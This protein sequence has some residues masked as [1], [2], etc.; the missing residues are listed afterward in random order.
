M[1]GIAWA[2]IGLSGMAELMSE[3]LGTNGEYCGELGTG[4]WELKEWRKKLEFCP[5][6]MCGL[7]QA[8]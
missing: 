5:A 8:L 1:D 3:R 4:N 6:V 2:Q 7:V